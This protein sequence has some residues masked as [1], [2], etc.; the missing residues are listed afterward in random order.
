[1]GCNTPLCMSDLCPEDT[2][3]E[4]GAGQGHGDAGHSAGHGH[5]HGGDSWKKPLYMDEIWV[6]TSVST[7][8]R[9]HTHTSAPPAQ[10]MQPTTK[11]C[12]VREFV[13]REA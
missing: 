3:A 1:M 9:A 5:G 8:A 6:L 13:W 12:G 11:L 7:H 4:H 2:D 10:Y